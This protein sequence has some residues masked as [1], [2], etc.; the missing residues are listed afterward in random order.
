[1]VDTIFFDTQEEFGDWLEE[2]T[3]ASELWVG[4][5]KKSAG[6]TSLTW[7]ES[8]DIAFCFGWI[9]GIRKKD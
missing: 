1:M 8:V 4:Y 5:F 9:D 2:H 3:E 7:S 6:R